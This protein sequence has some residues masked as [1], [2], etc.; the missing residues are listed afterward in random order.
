[1]PSNP[2]P[3][4]AF[5]DA[6]TDWRVDLPCRLLPPDPRFEIQPVWLTLRVFEVP[7]S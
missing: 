5:R 4:G 6:A 3:V 1:M 7:C 2:P